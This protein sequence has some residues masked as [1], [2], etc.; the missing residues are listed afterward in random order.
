MRKLLCRLGFHAYQHAGFYAWNMYRISC[1]R[2]GTA[3]AI[4]F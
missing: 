3:K 1:T 2:C 4:P